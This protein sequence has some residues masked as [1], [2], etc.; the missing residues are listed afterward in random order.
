[1]M[2]IYNEELRDL[3]NQEEKQLKLRERPDEVNY[4]YS[5]ISVKNYF[6]F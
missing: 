6:I 2:E 3:L 4:V 1:M 5:M